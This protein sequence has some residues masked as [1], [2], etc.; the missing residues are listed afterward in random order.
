MTM[1]ETEKNAFVSFNR[2]QYFLF[3][4][5]RTNDCPKTRNK[6]RNTVSL[7]KLHDSK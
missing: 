6:L 2:I 4:R 5:K 1:R 3:D 7:S